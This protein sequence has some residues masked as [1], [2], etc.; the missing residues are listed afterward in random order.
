M[1]HLERAAVVPSL[2]R[3][4]LRTARTRAGLSFRVLAARM[5]SDEQGTASAA[6]LNQIE[7][8]KVERVKPLYLRRIAA[9]LGVEVEAIST[10]RPAA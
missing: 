10:W 1:T 3:E 6:Y 2:D 7:S 9:A 5:K 4:K 8:G